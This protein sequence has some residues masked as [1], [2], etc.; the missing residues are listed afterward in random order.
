MTKKL[1]SSQNK[2]TQVRAERNVFGQLV[3]LSLEHD[4]DLQLT[5]SFPLGPVPWSLAT[6]D[7]MPTTTDKSK[8][9]HNLESG[10][11]PVTDRPSDA[12]HIIDGNAMLQSFK[13][14]PDTFDELAEHVF[15]RLPKTKR[16]DFVTDTYKSCSIK[17][18]E[19]ARSGTSPTFLL[20]G[21][22]TKTPHDWQSF[23]SNANNKTQLIKLLLEQWKTEK[24]AAKL[25]NRSIYYVCAE[26]VYS[27]TSENS[28][29]VSLHPEERL[30][31]DQ[32]ET[33]TR[34]ILHCLDI[35]RSLPQTCIIII[36]SPD[37]DVLMLLLKYC[38]QIKTQILF[39]TGMGNK[40]CLLNVNDIYKNK[41]ED[42]CSV[43]PALH[44]FTG[45]DTTSAFVR[46]GKMF[47]LKLVER[48]PEYI[49]FLQRIGQD[50]QCSESV[51]SDMEAF[52]CAIYG[53]AATKSVNKLP[54][55]TFLKK[56]QDRLS[57]LN[58]SNGMDTSLLPPCQS[59]LEMH[60]RR[61]N[62]QVF[63]WL[64]AHE[65]NPDLPDIEESGWKIHGEEI[66][67][68]WVKGDLIVPEQLVD[69][70]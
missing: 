20:A 21:A 24:Y 68:D 31:S 6:A 43:L 63:V 57:V 32:E 64:H 4:L 17:S 59:A 50:R 26:N 29:T 70:L 28:T 34:I 60:I 7:G 40:R 27:L 1:T 5:L 58:V 65:N 12:V 19:R 49:P 36:R 33:D 56:Y 53:N 39:D 41:G 61:V 3:L 8:L 46:R 9:L 44:C 14:I 37:T 35:S 15:N 69:I 54:Y 10:I 47:P 51:I 52:T 25:L 16:V 48:K 11:K 45:C 30:F 67:Y 42:I 55:D 22:K 38:K 18:Y 2:M 66:N 62:Y 13:P 23:M